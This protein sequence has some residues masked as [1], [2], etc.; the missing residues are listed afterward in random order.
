MEDGIIVR[1]A[2]PADSAGVLSLVEANA[3]SLNESV[4]NYTAS[5]EHILRDIN[6]GF[7]VYAEQ[8][9]G[10]PAGLMLFTYEWSDWRNGLFF[11]LQSVQATSDEVFTRMRAFLDGYMKERGCCGVRVY[12]PKEH[13]AHWEGVVSKMGLKESHYFIFHVGKE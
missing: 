2:T 10:S 13:K 1:I 8:A 5:A 12:Y 11:W 7:F 9:D 3:R 4:S 6:Y